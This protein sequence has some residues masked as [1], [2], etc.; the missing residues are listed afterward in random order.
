MQLYILAVLFI[1]LSITFFLYRLI[2]HSRPKRYILHATTT[3]LIIMYIAPLLLATLSTRPIAAAWDLDVRLAGYTDIINLPL[4]ITVMAIIN[5]VIDLWL[6]ALPIHSVL[7]L[8]M[9]LQKR[10][11]VTAIFLIGAVGCAGAVV[12]LVFLSPTLNSYD[13][14]CKFS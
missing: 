5:L 12:K 6:L 4:E 11:G 7:S 13:S 14:T 9:P 2:S 8:Q 1:R 3:V 10:I